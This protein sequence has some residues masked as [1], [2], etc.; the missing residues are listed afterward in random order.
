[1]PAAELLG[2]QTAAGVQRYRKCTPDADTAGHSLGTA[3]RRTLETRLSR[4]AAEGVRESSLKLARAQNMLAPCGCLDDRA[5]RFALLAAWVASTSWSSVHGM[6]P[7]RRR[8]LPWLPTIPEDRIATRSYV[9]ISEIRVKNAVPAPPFRRER[10]RRPSAAS[11]RTFDIMEARV[12]QRF[13][14][15]QHSVNDG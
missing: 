8:Q 6:H 9:S 7:R 12:V 3:R 1:M 14:H 2:D 5:E 13:D 15:R 10:R 11:A 4:P